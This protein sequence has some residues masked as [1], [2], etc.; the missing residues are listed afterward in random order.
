[1]SESPLPI[2][3]SI[4]AVLKENFWILLACVFA[5]IFCFLFYLLSK[6]KKAEEKVEDKVIEI[7]PFEEAFEQMKLLAE[8]SPRLAPKPF[9][10]KLSE[11]IRLFIERQFKLPALEQT[12]EEF[13]RGIAKHS[14]LQQKFEKLLAEF[15]FKGDRIKYSP[16]SFVSEDLDDLLATAQGFV[17]QVRHELTLLKVREKE[18]QIL[19]QKTGS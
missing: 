10:F 1:M 14:F 15:V 17:E 16:D 4:S 19:T 7:D 13:L 9:I 18:D 8:S 11:I 6:R 5:S 12:G 2:L 3:K